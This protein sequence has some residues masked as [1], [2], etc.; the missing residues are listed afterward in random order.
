MEF[1]Y[2]EYK[3][4]AGGAGQARRIAFTLAEQGYHSLQRDALD[5]LKRYLPSVTGDS[6]IDEPVAGA[7][8]VDVL[9]PATDRTARILVCER[10]A[11]GGVAVAVVAV[12]R[13]QDEANRGR[14]AAKLALDAKGKGDGRLAAHLASE[15]GRAPKTRFREEWARALGLGQTEA[16]DA[17]GGSMPR[18]LASSQALFALQGA[19]AVLGRPSLLR[20]RMD[21]GTNGTR[22]FD[23]A[24]LEALSTEGLI[25]RSFVLMCRESGQ[26][27]GVGKDAAEVQAAMQ[28][29]LRCPHCR[30]PLSEEVQDVVYSLNAQGE[31]FIKSTR[32]MRDAVESSLRRR[33]C[34]AVVLADAPNGR[35]DGAACYKDTV[36]L[37]R[38][39]DSAPGEDDLRTLAQVGAEFEKVAPGVPVRNV[40]V[41]TQP[42][43]AA[44][45]AA[46]G[47]MFLNASQLEDSVDRLLE[48]LKRDAFT[49]LT[50][51]MLEFIRP[52]PSTLLSRPG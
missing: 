4:S 47:C 16:S 38:L 27:V 41:T 5:L 43:P 14:T 34:D 46:G 1:E 24:Q 25:D 28:L 9:V 23:P 51:T 31:E 32:W 6:Q 52:D 15:N 30:R 50:G 13:T 18:S 36:L 2:F 21:K 42:A 8:T 35:V 7:R 33:N 29:T 17:G 45:S 3:F 10:P 20:S 19:Q 11:D 48:E 12:G 26:I 39:R 49:R 22:T 44:P 40:M 37:F